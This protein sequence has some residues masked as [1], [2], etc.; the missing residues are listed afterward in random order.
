MYLFIHVG[1]DGNWK[2][3]LPVGNLSQ[4]RMNEV[5]L[6]LTNNEFEEITDTYYTRIV[7]PPNETNV[8]NQY[9]EQALLEIRNICKEADKNHDGLIIGHNV[10][11][12]INV[13]TNEYFHMREDSRFLSYLRPYCTMKSSTDIVRIPHRQWRGKYK[14]PTLL[15][16]YNYCN[17]QNIPTLD[18]TTAL[19]KARC[20]FAIFKYLKA[21][22]NGRTDN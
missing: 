7:T 20:T 8:A 5:A 6:I 9:A 1:T 17:K 18:D 21:I 12:H 2:F 22:K 4:P 13:I 19:Q 16:A 14:W 10:T 3:N 11:H 15:E